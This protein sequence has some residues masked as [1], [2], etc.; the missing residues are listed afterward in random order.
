MQGQSNYIVNFGLSYKNETDG[1]GTTLVFNNIG[2]RIILVGNTLFPNVWEK[3]RN[4]ID[5]QISKEINKKLELSLGINDLLNAK[6][7]QYQNADNSS[8][9]TNKSILFVQSTTGTRVGFTARYK[10]K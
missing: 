7:I 8:K 5:W 6:F 4:L 2:P 1:I 9:F 3:S 10:L